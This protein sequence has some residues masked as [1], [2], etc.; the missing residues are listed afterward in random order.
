MMS[1]KNPT[2]N[3]SVLPSSTSLCFPQCGTISPSHN[4]CHAKSPRPQHS[5]ISLCSL[6]IPSSKSH[7]RVATFP[8]ASFQ[9]C[10]MSQSGTGATGLSQSPKAAPPTLLIPT[11]GH[12]QVNHH[13]LSCEFEVQHTGG[14]SIF[15]S[16]LPHC[17]T[18]PPAR[19]WLLLATTLILLHSKKTFFLS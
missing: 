2:T 3:H 9:G 8:V 14:R 18:F 13:G 7:A 12:S 4:P 6:L 15:D 5:A 19:P 10:L 11:Q 16:F 1:T 17:K